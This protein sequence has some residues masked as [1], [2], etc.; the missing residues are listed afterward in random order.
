MEQTSRIAN[1]FIEM[2]YFTGLKQENLSRRIF[3]AF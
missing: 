1:T 3:V 2:A